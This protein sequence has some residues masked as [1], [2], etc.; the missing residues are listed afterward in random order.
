MQ[1]YWKIAFVHKKTSNISVWTNSM[2]LLRQDRLHNESGWTT[3]V[4]SAG[5]VFTS[6]CTQKHSIMPV[7]HVSLQK[8]IE[9]ITNIRLFPILNLKFV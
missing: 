5:S 7:T 9:M 1:K 8:V 3:C 2:R 6:E 4:Q